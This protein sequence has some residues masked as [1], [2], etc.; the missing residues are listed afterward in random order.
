[1]NPEHGRLMTSVVQQAAEYGCMGGHECLHGQ[2]L[3]P[4]SPGACLVTGSDVEYPNP[5]R[6]DHP[7]L[8]LPV[9]DA[10]LEGQCEEVVHKIPPQ[11]CGDGDHFPYFPGAT[12]VLG[13]PS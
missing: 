2:G 13:A 6:G 5:L 7:S 11:F 9:F 8:L 1:M 12:I 3:E 10:W 4:G